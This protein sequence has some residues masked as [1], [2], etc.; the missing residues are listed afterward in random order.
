[1]QGTEKQIAWATEI[2]ATV[3]GIFNAAI[4]ELNQLPE[5]FPNKSAVI[6]DL[7]HRKALIDAA[8]YASD[9]INLFKDIHQTGKPLDDFL[10]VKAVYRVHWANTPGE[11]KI[12]CRSSD[13]P[14]Q[15]KE[16]TQKDL[17][18]PSLDK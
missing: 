2:Q 6:A 17:D 3:T 16:P 9:I 13:D 18:D 4:E 11:R 8:D 7:E 14:E 15:G 10:A 5:K 12:L 1:M